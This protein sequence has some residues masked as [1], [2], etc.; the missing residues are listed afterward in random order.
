[1][2]ECEFDCSIRVSTFSYNRNQMELSNR[3]HDR[4]LKK[5][6]NRC[7]ECFHSIK[8]ACAIQPLSISLD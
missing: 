2:D 1:M 4:I 6:L 5:K 8:I 3:S 7:E